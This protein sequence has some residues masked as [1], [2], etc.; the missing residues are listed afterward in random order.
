L[1]HSLRSL[2]RSMGRSLFISILTGSSEG[3]TAVLLNNADNLSTLHY[4]RRLEREAD[5]NGLKLMSRNGVELR[6]MLDLMELLQGKSS[7]LEPPAILNTHPVFQERIEA[8]KSKI[9][10]TQYTVHDHDRLQSIF[11]EIKSDY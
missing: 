9:G 11:K 6:G 10:S 7:D 2:F 5:E 1:R 4:S 3:M 8:I